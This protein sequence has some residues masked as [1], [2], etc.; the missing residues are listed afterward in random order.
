MWVTM[1]NSGGN[2]YVPKNYPPF[3]SQ[4]L[5]QLVTCDNK[6]ANT[7]SISSFT[8]PEFCIFH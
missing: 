4:A 7:F 1:A 5:N 8:P 3:I 2:L 6:V